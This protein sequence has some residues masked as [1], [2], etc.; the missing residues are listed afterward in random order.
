MFTNPPFS[1]VQEFTAKHREQARFRADASVLL[2]TNPTDS[3][4][5]QDTY[6]DADITL[7]LKG[8]IPFV[9]PET[10]KR[11]SGNTTGS[12]VFAWGFQPRPAKTWDWKAT[13]KKAGI[14]K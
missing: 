2:V 8:R 7:F 11:V 4:W 3:E 9:D 6:N 13:L 10:G 1:L 14:I 5:W 12:T